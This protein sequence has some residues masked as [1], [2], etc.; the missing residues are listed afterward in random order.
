MKLFKFYKNNCA[1]CYSVTR[2]LTKLNVSDKFDLVQLNVELPENKKMAVEKGIK[3][4]PVLMLEDGR[5]LEGMKTE[6]EIVEFLG[7]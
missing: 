2:T 1:P 4:V 7:L 6:K 5:M 3:I